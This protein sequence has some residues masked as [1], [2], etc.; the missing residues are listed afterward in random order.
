MAAPKAPDLGLLRAAIVTD[1]LTGLM[2][3]KD[4]NPCKHLHF[5]DGMVFAVHSYSSRIIEEICLSGGSKT[6]F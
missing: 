6:V 1:N 2:R 5:R 3:A 4:P